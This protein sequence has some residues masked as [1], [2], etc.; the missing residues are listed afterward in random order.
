M[1]HQLS[2]ARLLRILRGLTL[3]EVAK[4]CGLVI[5]HLSSIERNVDHAG[6]KAQ[7]SLSRFYKAPWRGVLAREIDASAIADS[8]ISQATKTK[9][10][11]GKPRSS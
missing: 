7:L 9:D 1:P 6:R 4:E 5:G 10:T 8:I 3:E 2:G 11:N